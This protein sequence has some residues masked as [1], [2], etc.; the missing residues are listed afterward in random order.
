MKKEPLQPKKAVTAKAYTNGGKKPKAE[1]T[2]HL[3][4]QPRKAEKSKGHGSQAP[5]GHGEQFHPEDFNRF[6][7]N[8]VST[9]HV[10]KGL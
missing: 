10:K 7:T 3:E 9:K 8:F 4:T 2:K 6:G 5:M 1:V